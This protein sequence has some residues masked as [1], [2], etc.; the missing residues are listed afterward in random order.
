[1]T[2]PSLPIRS[3]PIL[4][5]WDCHQCGQCCRGPIVRLDDDDLARLRDQHWEEHPEFRGVRTVEKHGLLFKMHT[6]AKLPDGSCV[7]LTP[8]NRCRIHELHGEEAKPRV[9]RLFPLQLVPL[10][11]VALLTVR[12]SCPSAAAELGQPVTKQRAEGKP[13]S[14]ADYSPTQAPRVLRGW[15][16]DWADARAAA[17]ALERMMTDQR[18]PL[19]RR[20][21]HVLQFGRLLSECHLRNIR[22]M[23]ARARRDLFE[24]LEAGATE[25]AGEW[26]RDR[27]PPSAA[28]TV[29]FRQTAGEYSRLHV[30]ST[31]RPTW[32]QRLGVAGAAI[33]LVRGQG[34]LPSLI[35]GFPE[36]QFSDLERPLGA[37]DPKIIAP[38]DG[39]FESLVAS[40]RY[41]ALGYSDWPMIEGIRAAALSYAVALWLW[42]WASGA[43]GIRAEEII[44][45]IGCLDRAT[46]YSPLLSARHRQR[47]ATISRSGELERL[48]AWYA[49]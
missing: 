7:F 25:N 2:R 33:K 16:R 36:I 38:L 10:D 20:W 9:C 15:P 27:Q 4:E 48:L 32:R 11:Q 21:I 24:V 46:G 26:F 49:R 41:A 17:A 8:D 5:H 22:K 1:V 31:V 35:E 34:T 44:P 14:P 47:V 6:L 42:R 29:L 43:E 39:Y 12:R 19:V 18:Y 23:D 45:I 40:W 13:Y 3:L 28:T 30:R 37:I